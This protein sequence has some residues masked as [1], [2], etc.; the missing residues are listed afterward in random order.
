MNPLPNEPEIKA[1]LVLMN[2][3]LNE[4]DALFLPGASGDRNI[5]INTELRIRDVLHLANTIPE[6]RYD[7]NNVV[8]RLLDRYNE[9]KRI[10]MKKFEWWCRPGEIGGNG[11]K[12]VKKIVMKK[13]NVKKNQN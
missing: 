9:I 4:A 6:D 5:F 8:T 2:Q 3:V 1:I 13:R 7:V 12:Q 11:G 10:L